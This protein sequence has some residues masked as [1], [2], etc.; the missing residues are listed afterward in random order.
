[1][2]YGG[3]ND[4]AQPRPSAWT[5][6]QP[7]I[8]S[9]SPIRSRPCW[10]A[11]TVSGTLRVSRSNACD[12]NRTSTAAGRTGAEATAAEATGASARGAAD[13]LAA[14]ATSRSAV[15][16]SL[17][18]P[19]ATPTTPTSSATGIATARSVRRRPWRD[20]SMG[21]GSKSTVRA[22]RDLV[23]PPT[24]YPA[25]ARAVRRAPSRSGT[26][27]AMAASPT[28][29]DDYERRSFWQATMPALPDRSGRPLPDTADVVVIG[30]GYAGINAARELARRG[31]AVTLLEAHTLG[32]GRLDP[33]RRHRP[34]RAT[35][36]D[37]PRCSSATATVTGRALYRETLES[38]ATRQ[39]AHR[40]RG[41]RLRL[42]RG[43]PSRARLR[44]VARPRARARP[45]QPRVRRR[46]RRRSSRATG[47][48][49]RSAP[50]PTTGRWPSRAAACSTRAATSPGSPR[51]R[52]GP[53]RTCTRAS[54]RRRSGGRATGGSSSRPTRGAILA[55]DVFVAT[56]GYTD[57]VVPALR[58]RVIPIG[59]YIIASEPLPDDLAHEL[60]PKGRVV[61]RHQ[62]LPVLLAR[63][64]RPPDDLRRTRELPADDRSIGRPRS[65]TRVCSRSTRSWP[66]YRIEYAWGGNV[67][68]TFDRMPHAGRTKDGVAYRARLLRDRR[69]ADD[70]ARDDGRGVAG[71]R[72]GPGPGDA[73]VPAG[74]GAVRGP[75]VVPAGRR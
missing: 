45:G 10:I 63:V 47:S 50:T 67:G 4:G 30:G 7:R 43:R 24:G 62:E 53:A 16:G 28:L 66:D 26:L 9:T 15:S 58:R 42:P 39:A 51:P 34:R 55:R 25:A 13:G 38:Y 31:T 1:M 57:G 74:P 19:I 20:V 27:A 22:S 64:G 35:S 69:R 6:I 23:V 60:S 8:A 33:E 59:S 73:Q 29:N 54:G 44:P 12:G 52:T 41:H 72:R 56:N 65:S 49:R 46:R 75:A 2:R 3:P 70:P 32:L 14:A 21:V 71:R 17:D 18:P 40:R 48:A 68:F 61:L 5:V 36:G 37:R 11:S